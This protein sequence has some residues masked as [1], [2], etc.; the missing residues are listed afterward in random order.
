MISMAYAAVPEPRPVGPAPA[1]AAPVEP[2]PEPE[3]LVSFGQPV[4]G[5]PVVSPWGLR[6]LPWERHGRLHAGVDIAAPSGVLVAAV[7]DG[8]VVGAGASPGYGRYVEVRHLD[9]LTSFYGH[10]GGVRKGLRQGVAVRGGEP[11]ARIGDTGTSTGPHLHFEIRHEG[12]PVNPLY[13]MNRSF[14]EADDLPFDQAAAVPKRVRIAYVSSIPESK[15]DEMAALAAK[16]RKSERGTNRREA[17][18]PDEAQAPEVTSDTVQAAST[19][20]DGR[21]YATLDLG[22]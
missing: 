20:A 19:G 18:D 8:V 1:T 21:V 6:R 4:A 11:I 7:A 5:Y 12:E 17:A 10:L 9:G 2:I 14:A 3:P 16:G 22:D 15:R 13:F